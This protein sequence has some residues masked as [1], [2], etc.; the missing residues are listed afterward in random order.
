MKTLNFILFFLFTPPLCF[1]GTPDLESEKA[2][3]NYSVGYQV[4]GDFK[5]QDVEIDSQALLMGIEDALKSDKPQISSEDMRATLVALKKKILTA[6]YQERQQ[7]QQIYR[8]EGLVFLEK[9]GQKEGV[10]TLA[11]G[12]QFKVLRSGKGKIPK[13]QDTVSVHY[14]GTLI[15]GTEFDKSM[16]NDK[17]AQFRVDNVIPGW[18]E[19]LQ[20]MKEGDKWQVFI[21]PTLAYGE[22]GPLADRTLVY[23]I[24]LVKVN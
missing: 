17:P 20:L 23:D 3:I 8:D 18:T 16:T 19:A 1:A 5:R 13:Q 9:N 6:Q 14:R 4:G 10:T 21:P 22:R 24:E 7:K 12:L 2:R 11:S 15:D